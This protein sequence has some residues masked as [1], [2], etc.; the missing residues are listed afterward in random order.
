MKGTQTRGCSIYAKDRAFLSLGFAIFSQTYVLQFGA[1]HENDR[2]HENDKDN[3][4][5]HKQGGWLLDLRK[6]RKA[7]KW[8][9]P[10]ESR[11]QNIGSPKPRFR[12]T[13]KFKE[14]QPLNLEG[15]TLKKARNSF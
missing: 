9:K 10:R 11:V 4:D 15:K 5:S 13:R 1:F 14:V 12:K 6:S 2:N 3:S 8:W 7:R